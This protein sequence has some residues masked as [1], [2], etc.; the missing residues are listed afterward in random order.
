[1]LVS[2]FLLCRAASFVVFFSRF[3]TTSYQLV[4]YMGKFMTPAALLRTIMKKNN[5]LSRSLKVTAMK[6][7]LPFSEKRIRLTGLY[8]A[9]F[10]LEFVPGEED[11]NS[12]NASDFLSL[13]DG[14]Y[15][16]FIRY[17][18][19]N[20]LVTRQEILVLTE[21]PQELDGF[22]K[23]AAIDSAREI[24]MNCSTGSDYF[25]PCDASH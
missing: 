24:I 10:A 8:L 25:I 17:L 18:E 23:E 19:T 12:W 6:I 2:A 14:V 20:S 16:N 5:T 13:F 3:V 9:E 15:A 22:I 21:N 11:V 4:I 1:M 7:V